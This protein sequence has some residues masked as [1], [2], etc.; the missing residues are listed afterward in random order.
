M[1]HSRGAD[2][3]DSSERCSCRLDDESRPAAALAPS[4]PRRPGHRL[5][6]DGRPGESAVPGGPARLR[7]ARPRAAARARPQGRPGRRSRA[8]RG[9][10]RAGAG[11]WTSR[12]SPG[13]STS[14]PTPT[15]FEAGPGAGRRGLGRGAQLVPDQR[16]V[17][18]QP[19]RAARARARRRPGRRAAQRPLEHDRRLHPRRPDARRSWHPR[20]TPSWAS[21][22]AWRPRRS[23][24]ALDRRPRTRWAPPPCRPPTSAR[25]PTWPRWPRW[26][27]RTGSRWWST[28]PGARTWPSTRTCPRTR[29]RCGADL[30]VSSTHKIVGSLTQSAMVHLGARRR[31]GSTPA[32]WTARSR[33]WSP[34]APTRCWSR[35]LDAARRLAATRGRRAA[36]RDD[37]GDGGGPRGG[38]RDRRP[39]RA[40][41]AARW[42][43]P[44]VHA[45]DP[46]RL[47]IDVRGTGASGYE[48][49]RRCCASATTSS[50]S[51]P[52]ENV[53]VGRVRHGRARRAAGR[54]AASPRCATRW[55]PWATAATARARSSR[56]RRRGASWRCRRATRSSARR[57]SWPWRTPRGGSPPSRW[58][59]TR[60]ASPTCCP[61]ERLTAE[62]LDYIHTTLDHGGSLRGA[63]DR[64]LRTIRVVASELGDRGRDRAA[65]RRPA[66]P[67]GPLRWL[68]TSA[69]SKAALASGRKLTPG[70]RRWPPTARWSPPTRTPA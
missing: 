13:A 29:S 43:R 65:A 30:V 58:P 33:S 52:G 20:S 38:A 27:T 31:A 44:G 25:W 59:P 9:D 10:R 57:R 41:R 64:R 28:R 49:A 36:G 53:I 17:A 70:R 12:R 23:T 2:G 32:S 15:P 35:S 18:G 54:A 67:A 24:R 50:S 61:G 4:T 39:R 63:S 7:R 19:R 68:P 55:A 51:S 14:G 11:A 40:R 37:R 60:R 48:L 34:P 21:P 47:A 69:I 5:A 66:R 56:R 22:T 8:A 45:Y 3:R 16:R 46:L 1:L 62:T 6:R 42:A 26:P